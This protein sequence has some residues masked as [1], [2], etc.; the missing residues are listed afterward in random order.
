MERK[1]STGA[2]L[3]G[4]DDL[5]GPSTQPPPRR[6]HTPLPPAPAVA[7]KMSD[8]GAAGTSVSRAESGTADNGPV[9]AGVTPISGST[10]PIW[11]GQ[12]L[13]KPPGG[14]PDD[15]PP[16]GYFSSD[17]VDEIPVPA[18]PSQPCTSGCCASNGGHGPA[19]PPGTGVGGIDGPPHSGTR[20]VGGIPNSGMGTDSVIRRDPS[21]GDKGC[22]TTQQPVRALDGMPVV[23]ATD[24]S[25]DSLG[26]MWGQTR[27]WT[28]LNNGSLNGWTISQLPYLVVGGGT[29]GSCDPHMSCNGPPWAGGWSRTRLATLRG[30]QTCTATN[31]MGRRTASIRMGC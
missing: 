19:G 24:L 9:T 11:L 5:F 17:N 3:L 25:S 22:A 18:D 1:D 14:G 23:T 6:T 29:N 31:R 8:A 28:G 21:N 26:F 30:M 10:A 2:D 15:D 27:S 20:G 4:L 13:P 12:N 7:E 16:P